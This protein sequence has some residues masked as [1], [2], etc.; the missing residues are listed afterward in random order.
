MFAQF[1]PETFGED[2]AE[3][4]HSAVDRVPSRFQIAGKRTHQQDSAALPVAHRAPEPGDQR[5]R[6]GDVELDDA[7]E[8]CGITV[9]ELG[10]VGVGAGIVYQQPDL[11][12]GDR[13][14]PR[15]RGVRVGEVGG[16]GADRHT[17]GPASAAVSSS[18]P[19]RRATSSR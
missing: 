15:R 9:E 12:I 19:G 3:S 13:V 5:E 16:Q 10:A 18:G 7:L 4:L 2:P 17:Q 6:G 14:E 8:G 1:E 11:D